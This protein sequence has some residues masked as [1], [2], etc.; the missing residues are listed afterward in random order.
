MCHQT[1]MQKRFFTVADHTFA[2]TTLDGD[3]LSIL[4]NL[5]PFECKESDDLLF[6]IT[7]DNSIQPSWRGEKV[8]TFP[9]PSAKFEVYRQDSGA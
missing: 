3:I 8:G 1:N 5:A 9:C 6:E 4:P 2:I 7:L